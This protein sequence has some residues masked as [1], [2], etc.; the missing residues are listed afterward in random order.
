MFRSKYFEIVASL[1]ATTPPMA[2]QMCDQVET[3]V[4]IPK[5]NPP[6]FA[7]S[8]QLNRSYSAN[9]FI[10]IRLVDHLF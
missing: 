8:N 1:S 9:Q 4:F 10:H 7:K 5:L 3:Q 2:C 6:D